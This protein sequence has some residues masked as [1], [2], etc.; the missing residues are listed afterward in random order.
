MAL[1]VSIFVAYAVVYAL[2]IPLEKR[3]VLSADILKQAKRQFL[4]DISL[5]MIAAGMVLFY[6]YCL[7]DFPVM[8]SGGS[9]VIGFL[10]TGFF[11]AL[12]MALARERIII[13]EALEAG[14]TVPPT[15][16]YPMTR[17]F[18]L[19]GLATV[20]AFYYLFA[21]LLLVPLPEG[22]LFQ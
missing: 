4:L 3:I 16:L 18:S 7:H 22:S 21:K 13:K 11:I 15:R 8:K 1:G 10:A 20:I 9:V 17:K 2:R 12:D 5:S 14:A 6:N 19:V